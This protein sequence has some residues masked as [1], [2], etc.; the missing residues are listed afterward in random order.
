MHHDFCIYADFEAICVPNNAVHPD[1]AA[2]ST[3]T[4]SQHVPCGFCYIIVKADGTLLKPPVLQFGESD[5]IIK[6]LMCLKEEVETITELRGDLYE[7]DMSDEQEKEFQ[8]AKECYMCGDQMPRFN[9]KK[10]RDHDWSKPTHNFRGAACQYPCNLNLKRKSYIP[11]FM[12]NLKNYDAHMILNEIGKLSDGSDLAVVPRTKEK[13]VSFQWGLLRF[14]DS[15]GFLNSSL[16]KLVADLS[17]DEMPLLK[18]VFP[19]NDDRALVSRKGVYP[20]SYFDSFAKFSETCLPPQNAFRN[21]LTGMDVTPEDYQHAQN[22][23]RHFKMS[24]LQDYHNLYLLTDTVLLA[25]CMENFRKMS[26]AH[27]KLD[28]V[29]YYTTPGMAF[30]ASLLFTKQRLELLDDIDIHLTFERGLRGGVASIQERYVQAN[31]RYVPETYSESKPTSFIMYYDANALYSTALCAKLPTGSFR[32]L[33]ASEIE[34]FGPEKIN[35]DSDLGYLFVVDLV[36]PKELHD[37]HNFYPLAPE[38]MEPQYKDLSRLQKKMIRDYNLPKKS[39]KKLIPNLCDK[40]CYVV[41]GDTL[42]LYLELGLRLE[43]IHKIIEFEQ[44]AW[45]KP[46]I[47]HNI[48]MRKLA[49]S[50]FQKAFW[51][52]MNNSVFGKTCEA[53]RKRRNVVLT[54][55]RQK[56]RK[57]VRSP[58]Y[59]SFE[60]FNHGLA[61]VERRKNKIVLN[62]PLYVGQ[63][64]LDISKKIMYDFYY[65][66]LKVKY[67]ENI[68]VLGGDTD[69]I[70]VEIVT[71]DVYADMYEMREYFDTSDYPVSHPLHSLD[72]KKVMGKF[73][74]ELGSVPIHSFIGLRAKMYSFKTVD[75]KEKSVGKGIPRAALKSQLTFNDYKKCITQFEGKNVSYSKIATDRKHGVFTTYCVK[76]GLSCYD[77]KRFILDD[78]ISTLAYGHYKIKQMNAVVDS[79]DD[80]D[81]CEM[82]DEGEE[83]LQDLIALLDD[84]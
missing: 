22:V 72:N 1:P 37:K 32:H 82:I 63:V 15:L 54:K 59:H 47:T 74:D 83:N 64:C 65:N 25:D 8:A 14:L 60:I 46:F 30:S 58:L 49:T 66:V 73:S 43:K 36:Y 13:Y 29:H 61:C 27:Y 53:V 19:D 31:N 71:E 79:D 34:E 75:N 16:D 33:T 2:S 20:Y 9:V 51:K 5:L 24:T 18:T 40:K 35:P 56:F 52:L 10:V 81:D 28:P 39:T 77:D 50:D 45:L 12:H 17:E 80:G 57:L 76:K 23:Y 41:Y 21:D 84:V 68:K 11:V 26:M 62:R 69:S 44:S 7:L 38:H 48:D 78:N 67:G 42:M 3:T 6:F 70:I 4:T 55:E